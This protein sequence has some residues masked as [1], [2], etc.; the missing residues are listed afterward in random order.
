VSDL[1]HDAPGTPLR[2]SAVVEAMR[3]VQVHRS[4]DGLRNLYLTLLDTMLFVP[5]P[6][7]A[8]GDGWT[9]FETGATL[10]VILQSDDDG[11]AFLA[12][13]SPDT[14]LRW[15]PEGS[16]YVAMNTQHVF[17]M[18]SGMDVTHVVIDAG[19]EVWSYWEHHELAP[20]T[21][22]DPP[23]DSRTDADDDED[24]DDTVV[25]VGRPSKAP[26]PDALDAVVSSL[27][28]EPAATGA[29]YFQMFSGS[30][31]E[32]AVAV[33]FREGTSEKDQ[34][35]AIHRV[36]E[37][38]AGRSREASAIVFVNADGSYLEPVVNGVGEP[39]FSK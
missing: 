11:T 21:L 9:S 2:S 22:G 26:H 31:P 32:L 1:I 39:I 33:R 27:L 5:I 3:S 30:A 17:E 19:S 34:E 10:S 12:F 4:H 38:A 16:N 18:A 20:L 23:L 28:H 13:T 36:A 6:A 15:R 37:G 29:W 14:I 8:D 35:Q 24:G 25:Y 7:G